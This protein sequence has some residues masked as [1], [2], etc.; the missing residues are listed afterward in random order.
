MTAIT[1]NDAWAVGTFRSGGIAQTLVERW[2]GTTWGVVQSPN[3]GT[4]FNTL[5]GISAASATDIWAVG[6]YFSGATSRTLALHWNGTAWSVSTTPNVG[7]QANYLSAVSARAGGDVW[8][9]GYYFVSGS[10]SQT[11]VEHWDGATWNVVASPNVGTGLNNLR[12]VAALAA[13]D[14]WAVGYYCTG[15]CGSSPYQTLTEHWNGST[16][17]IVPSVNVG[18]G[19]NYLISVSPV[20]ANNVWAVGYYRDV[21]T[22]YK[23]LV[24]HWNIVPCVT[25]SATPTGTITPGTATP[26]ATN[27][28][29]NTP[30]GTPTNTSTPGGATATATRTATPCPMNFSDVPP[31]DP[32]YTYIRYL[33]CAGVIS[34]YNDGT[35]RPGNNTTRGQLSKI[36]VLAVRWSVLCP[37]TGHFSDVP[38]GSVFFCFVETAY[39]HGTISGYNDGTFRPGNSATRAQICKIVYIA[40]T[41]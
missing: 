26:S 30:V 14:V 25:P 41:Q 21:D 4:G 38:V 33:Y 37:A 34:G 15:S 22:T 17:N 18:S 40:V 36:V 20:G 12:G 8:A 5:L 32:F 11:L 19:Y 1:A 9:V 10:V 27:T 13:N 6:N 23:T 29:T 28:N 16:W 7:T 2:N 39:S 24:E 31:T 3:A 35:F